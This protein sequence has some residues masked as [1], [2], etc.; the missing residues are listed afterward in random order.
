MMRI[1]MLSDTGAV[2]EGP[3]DVAPDH[4]GFFDWT[5]A[6]GMNYTGKFNPTEEEIMDEVADL[7]NDPYLRVQALY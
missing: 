4:A 5:T 6:A 2:L 1:W 3:F 7:T